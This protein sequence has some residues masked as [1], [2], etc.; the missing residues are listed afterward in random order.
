MPPINETRA[1]Q[2]K[3]GLTW[4]EIKNMSAYHQYKAE[5]RNMTIRLMLIGAIISV[6]ALGL[7]LS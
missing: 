4:D 5:T 7:W 3:R 1:A 6:I 2:R